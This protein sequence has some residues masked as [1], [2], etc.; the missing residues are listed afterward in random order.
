MYIKN[1]LFKFLLLKKALQKRDIDKTTPKAMQYVKQKEKQASGILDFHEKYLINFYEYEIATQKNNQQKE[2]LFSNIAKAFDT[3]TIVQ[4]LKNACV[5]L[6]N[7]RLLATANYQIDI[8]DLIKRAEKQDLKQN[9]LFKLYYL[10]FLVLIG[11]EENWSS[12]LSILKNE[13]AIDELNRGERKTIMMLAINFCNK[14][15]RSGDFNYYLAQ[16]EL[17]QIKAKKGDLFEQGKLPTF[18]YKNIVRLACRANAFEDAKKFIDTYRNKVASRYSDNYYH[19]NLAALFFYQND[20]EKTLQNL[21]LVGDLE[22]EDHLNVEMLYLKTF[23]ALVSN[24]DENY[25]ES[26]R[27]R[28]NAFKNYLRRKKKILKE[29]WQSYKNFLDLFKKIFQLYSER[30]TMSNEEFEAKKAILVLQIENCD[31]LIDK[32]WLLQQLN[33]L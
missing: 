19:L 25:D 22:K 6:N 13:A 10:L 31:S 17:Y 18:H 1:V 3:Y 27:D 16:F 5:L 24:G 20:Y 14:K 8:D 28:I 9:T 7:Q 26:L 23:Y 11:K 15:L 30:N 12:L 2:L 21:V 33:D 32:N 29:H 4:E